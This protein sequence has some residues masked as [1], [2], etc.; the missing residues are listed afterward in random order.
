MFC[1]CFQCSELAKH[2]AGT[3]RQELKLIFEILIV[4]EIRGPG[5]LRESSFNFHSFPQRMETTVPI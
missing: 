2:E 3:R 5:T 1:F 4:C